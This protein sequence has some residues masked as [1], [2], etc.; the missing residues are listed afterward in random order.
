LGDGLQQLGV[1]V[2]YL[3]QSGYP[4][5][6]L[7]RTAPAGPEVRV[8]ASESSQFASGLM[9]VAPRLAGGLRVSLEGK[10]VS[11]PYLHMTSDLMRQAGADVQWPDER[12]VVVRPGA[13]RR[14]ALDGCIRIEPDWSGAAFLLAAGR[15]AGVEVY[16]EGLLPPGRS[17]QGDARFAAFL[18]QMQRGSDD[19]YDLRDTPD[20]IAPLA[21][22]GLY[23]PAPTRIRG[24]QHVRVKESDRLGVLARELRKLGARVVEHPDGLDLEP[25]EAAPSGRIEMDP[26]SDHRMA[27]AFGLLSL[28]VPG[29]VVR[30]P[31]CVGKSF[32][33]FWQALESIRAGGR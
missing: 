9:L 20:L 7:R 5:L 2:R 11:R 24:A 33:E 14:E 3:G 23:A 8:D 30:D 17:L 28:R 4:P 10:P 31:G 27:M 19:L 16:V 15:L 22:L 26:A 25:L 1:D 13:Y 32:P 6:R 21:A 29:I 18:Q 12:T